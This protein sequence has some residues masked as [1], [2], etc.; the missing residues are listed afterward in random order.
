MDISK[1]ARAYDVSTRTIRYYEELGLLHPDRT[2]G[3]SRIYS[4]AELVKLKLILRGKRYGFTLE[5]IKEMILLFDKDRTGIKQLER[6]IHFGHEKIGQVEAKIQELTE[7]KRE[8]E[9][10]LV[11]FAEKL[12]NIKGD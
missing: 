1:V 3:N 10:L 9:Q 12:T 4:K 6:T 11:Q 2:A 5:E 7:M 8:M